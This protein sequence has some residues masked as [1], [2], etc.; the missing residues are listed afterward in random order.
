MVR[1]GAVRVRTF[2][3]TNP[4]RV[5]QFLGGTCVDDCFC[6]NP[7]GTMHLMSMRGA[8]AGPGSFR[9][10]FCRWEPDSGSSDGTGSGVK[11]YFIWIVLCGGSGLNELVS[12]WERLFG[13]V[14]GQMWNVSSLLFLNFR[15]VDNE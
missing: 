4:S 15:Q 2:N 6:R 5:A 3:K 13:W 1:S 14:I 12:E 10:D 7:A 11:D 8:P 9:V